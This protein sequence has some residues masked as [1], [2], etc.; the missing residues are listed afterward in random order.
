[1]TTLPWHMVYRP[2]GE[3]NR[4]VDG[5]TGCPHWKP[6][7]AR[8]NAAKARAVREKVNANRKSQRAADRELVEQFAGM[9]A[10]RS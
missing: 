7:R 6:E 3:C 9:L 2:C 5:E 1:M 8:R 10:R 4:L